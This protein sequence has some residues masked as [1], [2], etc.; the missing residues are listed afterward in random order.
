MK[1]ILILFI[2]IILL[3]ISSNQLA[4]GQNKT[5]TPTSTISQL[6]IDEL[7]NKIAS[8]VAELKLVEKRGV[9]GTVTDISDTQI[10]LT[11]YEKNLKII[12][13]DE[14]T[15]FY[16]DDDSFGI[17][18]IKK[19][20]TIGVL[21]LY[22]KDSRRILAREINDVEAPQK[23]IL[24]IITNIDKDNYELSILDKTN[25]KTVVIIEDTTK[26]FAFTNDELSKS[27][28]SKIKENETAVIA[29]IKD[30]ENPSK[31]LGTRIILLPDIS[32]TK[33]VNNQ[34]NALNTTAS[35]SATKPL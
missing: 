29:G 31:L 24:G 32:L 35:S 26:T 18:D 6:Q 5:A 22:N 33:I 19:G 21:G 13:V 3:T 14:L 7:K 11:D 30:K 16:S 27:G 23:I 12:D 34:Q 15:K 10:T 8:K 17:S 9:L 20:H 28:F 4:L 2:S 25:A 1:K